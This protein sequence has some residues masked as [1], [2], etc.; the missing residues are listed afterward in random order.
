MNHRAHINNMGIEQISLLN[1]MTTKVFIV[2]NKEHTK[3]MTE[4]EVYVSF[5]D[6]VSFG[7][8]RLGYAC[9]GFGISL[10]N[11]LKENR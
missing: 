4:R 11:M 10:K 9:S 1:L 7:F 8:T 3:G 5:K 2:N 6:T